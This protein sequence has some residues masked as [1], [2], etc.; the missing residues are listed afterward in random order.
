MLPFLP[1]CSGGVLD[2]QGPIGAA[3]GLILINSVEIML[4]IV[5]P[6]IVAAILFAWWYRTSNIRARYLPDWSYSGRIELVVW[7]IPILVVLFLSGLIWIGSHDLDP[8]RPINTPKV[9]LEV[10][11]VALDWKWLFLYPEQGVASVNELVIPA[12]APIHFLLTSATVMNNFFVPQLGSMIAT[13]NGMRTQLYL[14]ADKPGDYYGLST[15]FS[16]DGFSGMHFTVR[17]VPDGDFEDWVAQVRQSGPMLDRAGYDALNKPSMNVRPFTY[18]ATDPTLF[19]AVVSQEIPPGAGAIA[20][21]PAEPPR[22]APG[23]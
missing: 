4:T 9:P 1:G 19:D 8:A 21:R 12:G 6:T 13:M 22:P 15:Q 3:N 23:G 14:Q 11:V 10:Q 16:G 18:R 5:V 17:A 7:S 20:G 2:P